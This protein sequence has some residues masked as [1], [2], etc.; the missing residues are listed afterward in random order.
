MQEKN[1]SLYMFVLILVFLIFKT[2]I[3][4][5]L[6]NKYYNL[7][8][9]KSDIDDVKYEVRNILNKQEAAN[10]LA[11]IKQNIIILKDYLTENINNYDLKMQS[12]IKQ[13][14]RNLIN[15][16]ISESDEYSK[17]TSY[18]V[19]KGEKIVFC[20]RSKKKLLYNLHDLNLVMYVV[21]HELAHV[22]CPEYGHTQ[23]FKQIFTFLTQ[24]A[25]KLNLYK[26]IEFASSPQEYCGL[27]IAESV[28]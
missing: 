22:A 23:L 7:I 10:M 8:L 24:V 14:N 13:L 3:Y 5:K 15:I 21:L 17:F 16:N 19:N 4:P 26:K 12:Y 2:Y 11:R 1:I 6:H 28:V 20:L 27:T 25:I 18:S 9:Y